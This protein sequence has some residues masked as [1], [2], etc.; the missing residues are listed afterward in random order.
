MQ[1]HK[2]HRGSVKKREAYLVGGRRID[3]GNPR[4]IGG[5]R[6]D[7]SNHNI[8]PHQIG[9]I[10][11]VGDIYNV[12]HIRIE[13]GRRNGFVRQRVG[14][15]DGLHQHGMEIKNGE[16][17]GSRNEIGNRDIK[18]EAENLLAGQNTQG[19]RRVEKLAGRRNEIA[20]SFARSEAKTDGVGHKIGCRK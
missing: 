2:R 11:H 7:G 4:I 5:N 8:S 12:G 6:V 15:G 10:G 3:N 19:H 17:W 18:L 16:Q 1:I 9:D 13:H 20:G 14:T